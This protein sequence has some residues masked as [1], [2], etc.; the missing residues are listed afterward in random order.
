MTTSVRLRRAASL[1]LLGLALLPVASCGGGGGASYHLTAVFEST[2]GLYPSGDVQVMG[3]PV[4][5]V[6]D[7]EIDGTSVRVEMTIDADVPLPADVQATIGQT[8]L[9]GERN[10]VLFPPWDAAHEA[11]G[12]GRARDGDVIPRARTQVPVEPDEG[13]QAFNDLAESLDADVV[14]GFVTDAADVLDG[15]GDDIGQAIDQAAGLG[16]TLSEV[17]QQ[18]VAAAD[19]L[20]VLAGSLATREEQLGRLVDSFSSA[21]R[22]LADERQGISRFLTSI[23]ELTA[24]GK[25]LLDT[26]GDQLPGDIATAT[27]LAS[28]LERNTGSANQLISTFPLLAEGIARSYQPA[29]D[30]IY[31]R[32]NITP[33]VQSLLDILSDQLGVLPQ[34]V[35]P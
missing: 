22:V 27:A 24:Q 15:R 6:D 7:I 30:G 14:R 8:Q 34:L 29:I 35:Q 4:G 17:D 12:A 20:H 5:H 1:A 26:Y 25:E 18:L 10:V 11:A 13:L 21:T 23:V 3:M 2:I 32:A 16:R 19:H 31:L 9:I 28:I 33:T